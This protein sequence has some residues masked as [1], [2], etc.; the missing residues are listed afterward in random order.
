MNRS[1]KRPNILFIQ[2]DQLPPSALSFHG[3]P[4]TKTPHLDRL[5]SESAIFDGAYCNYPLCGPSRA[6]MMTR[7][8]RRFT[9]QPVAACTPLIKQ[10]SVSTKT[11]NF[12]CRIGAV[13]SSASKRFKG[14]FSHLTMANGDNRFR[15]DLL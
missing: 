10:P 8:V 4:V 6:S 3:N 15:Y 2:V 9:L 14:P 13:K 5:A 12:F 11:S 1:I 7:K